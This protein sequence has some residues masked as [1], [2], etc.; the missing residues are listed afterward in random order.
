MPTSPEATQLSDVTT[1]LARRW[2]VVAAVALAG[3]LLGVCAFAVIP[4]RYKAS[5]T[6]AVNPMS[7]DPLTTT[8]DTT[9]AVNM[10]TEEA[11]ITSREVASAASAALRPEVRISPTSLRKAVAVSTPPN[12]LIL[13]IDVTA[14][15]ADHAVAEANAVAEAYLDARRDD[16]RARVDRLVEETTKQLASVT[17]AADAPDATA[18]RKRPLN[19]RSDALAE[20]L[21]RLGTFDVDP[22]QVVSRAEQPEGRS[23]PS[24]LQLGLAGLF[25]GLLFGI[26]VALLRKEDDSEIG[27]IDRLSVVSGQIVLDGTRDPHRSDTWDIAAFMLRLPEDLGDT[28]FTIMVDADD[29]EQL[30]APGEELVDALARRGRHAHFVDASAINEGKIRRG[31]PTERKISSWAG[32]IIVID[33]TLISSAANK[34]AIASRSDAVLLA[35]TTTDDATA[36]RR[37][38][39]LLTSRDVAITLSCL[40]PSRTRSGATEPATPPARHAS[41]TSHHPI[42]PTINSSAPYGQPRT[43]SLLEPESRTED[44]TDD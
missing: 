24:L 28:A 5:S 13:T 17:K 36:L 41:T 6:V 19:V 9:R 40:F 21:A 1:L 27:T 42:Q 8:V 10:P 4:A 39:G 43:I 31:W 35:R 44:P 30:V 22:G 14:D 34:V 7:T 2:K 18:A 38:V 3:L 16:A 20:N 25:L 12:S 29:N 33:T 11:L 26:P 15:S 23:T 37:L 32:K